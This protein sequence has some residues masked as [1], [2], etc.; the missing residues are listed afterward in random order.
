[1]VGAWYFTTHCLV[2]LYLIRI[3]EGDK[4]ENGGFTSPESV[5]PSPYNS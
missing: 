5:H 3:E 1:M 2:G 4:F